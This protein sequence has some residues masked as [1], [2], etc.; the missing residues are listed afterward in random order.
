MDNFSALLRVAWQSILVNCLFVSEIVRHK[1]YKKKNKGKKK[2]QGQKRENKRW[3]FQKA[4]A[5]VYHFP[6]HLFLCDVTDSSLI[7]L[8]LRVF[9]SVPLPFA[10]AWPTLRRTSEREGQARGRESGKAEGRRNCRSRRTCPAGERRSSR[11]T[12]V[13]RRKRSVKGEK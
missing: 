1:V 9:A 2:P 8:H 5:R 11:G 10:S 12:E 13:N 4:C 7:R 3:Q 6:F